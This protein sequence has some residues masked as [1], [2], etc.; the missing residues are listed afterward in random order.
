MKAYSPPLLF[1][2]TTQQ[3]T[4]FEKTKQ[5]GIWTF[6]IPR[7]M[8]G[9]IGLKLLPTSHKETGIIPSFIFLEQQ[10]SVFVPLVLHEPW[11]YGSGVLPHAVTRNVHDR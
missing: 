3:K 2:T 10:R 7:N 8:T 6:S 5:T 1:A 11:E 9:E 4:K